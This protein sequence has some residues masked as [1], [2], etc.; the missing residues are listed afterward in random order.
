MGTEALS[1]EIKRTVCEADL[2]PPSAKVKNEWSYISTAPYILM[3]N[4]RI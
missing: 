2:S 1:R 3:A 4:I